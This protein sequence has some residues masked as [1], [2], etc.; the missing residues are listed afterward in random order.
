MDLQ[1]VNRYQQLAL[2]LRGEQPR[3]LLQAAPRG[4]VTFRLRQLA[5]GPVMRNFAWN[6][7]GDWGGKPWSAELPTDSALLL[8]L[9][10]AFLGVSHPPLKLLSV[11]SHERGSRTPT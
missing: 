9:F 10:A 6:A 5:E 2:L 7:G 3:N 11:R 1:A 8:F 4:Y